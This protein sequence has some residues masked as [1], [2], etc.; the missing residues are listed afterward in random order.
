MQAFDA[1]SGE[2][3]A[4]LQTGLLDESRL[5]RQAVLGQTLD[6]PLAARGHDRA[7]GGNTVW[8]QFL[9]RKGSFEATYD[10]AAFDESVQG[11]LG[12]M[13]TAI[14]GNTRLGFFGG[15][16][17]SGFRV[18]GRGSTAD[19]DTFH[20]GA[21]G[22]SSLGPVILRGGASW[23]HHDVETTR[24]VMFP[25]FAETETARYGANTGQLFGEVGYRINAGAVAVEPFGGFAWVHMDSGG[26]SEQGGAAALDGRAITE[27]RGYATL[28]LRAG[29]STTLPNGMTVGA[30]GSLAWQHLFGDDSPTS[31]LAFQNAS[32]AA[33]TVS[34]A[35]FDRNTAILEAGV[36]LNL[37]DSATLGI[38]YNATLGDRGQSQ[39]VQASFH[40]HF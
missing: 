11:V 24:S 18:P 5:V 31:D 26:F 20:I 25:G 32:P 14:N 35:P 36:D 29:T 22:V 4:S 12:G 23:S 27:D 21:Y 8:T 30:H 17:H 33:F 13:E 9:G 40:L 3:D 10:T 37:S 1:I 2:I 28:G 7:A 19:V 38:S 16:T 6:F 39:S 15:Q 34:G